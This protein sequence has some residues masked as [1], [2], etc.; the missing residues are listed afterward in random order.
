MINNQSSIKTKYELIRSLQKQRIA[1]I[2]VIE[3]YDGSRS[4]ELTRAT[5]S[6]IAKSGDITIILLR[7]I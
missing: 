7:T 5:K 3:P 1:Q 6:M 2:E 4:V